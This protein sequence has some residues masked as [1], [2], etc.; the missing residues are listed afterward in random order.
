MHGI[1]YNQQSKAIETLNKRTKMNNKSIDA[2][3]YKD[4]V[5]KQPRTPR[6]E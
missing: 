2:A 4:S 3:I 1:Q 5:S 6:I